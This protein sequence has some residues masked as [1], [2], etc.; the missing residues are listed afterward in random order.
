MNVLAR[1]VRR[2]RRDLGMT[3][4]DLAVRAA[5]SLATIQNIE[6]GRAN[7]ALSTLRRILAEVGIA[8]EWRDR[9]ADWDALAALGLPLG[10]LRSRRPVLSAGSLFA[11]L[12]PAL[13]EVSVPEATGDRARKV[14]ALEA[15]LLALRH[16][17]PSLYA[18]RLARSPLVRSLLPAEP[19]GRVVK[20]GRIA[21]ASLA[22]YL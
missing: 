18:R 7:P 2:R 14:E 13:V 19:S 22:E 3:Q 11:H 17:Y 5:V 1:L 16:H 21:R 15:L 9:A 12:V 8:P 20:L 6:T 4:S 10:R